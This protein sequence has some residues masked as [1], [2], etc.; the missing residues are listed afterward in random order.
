MPVNRSQLRD[1]CPA[2][3]IGFLKSE[4]IFISRLSAI[5]SAYKL[6]SFI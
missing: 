1:L 3:A 6:F 2:A 4:A 5:S